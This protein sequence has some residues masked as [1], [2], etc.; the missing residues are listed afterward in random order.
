MKLEVDSNEAFISL[1]DPRFC[2]TPNADSRWA[3][4]DAAVRV[5]ITEL[6][7]SNA[8]ERIAVVTYF[9]DMSGISPPI[10]KLS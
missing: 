4:L 2:Q 8:I 1:N 9:S 5:F 7:Q 10:A 3:A 6:D